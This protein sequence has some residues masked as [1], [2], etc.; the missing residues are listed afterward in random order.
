MLHFLPG[1]KSVTK[2]LKK[3]ASGPLRDHGTKWFSDL[4]DKGLLILQEHSFCCLFIS[5]DSLK[6]VILSLSGSA[7]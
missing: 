3:V 7:V 5:N 4:S 2:A 6:V 1:A